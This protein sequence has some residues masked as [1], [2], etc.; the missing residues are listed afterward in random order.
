MPPS[1]TASVPTVSEALEP[2]PQEI[3]Q[4]AP[5]IFLK[6]LDLVGSKL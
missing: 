5:A 6:V 3:D 2:S 4:V 1:L